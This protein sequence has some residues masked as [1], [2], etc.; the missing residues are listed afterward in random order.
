MS[1]PPT[2]TN[3]KAD[4]I[5]RQ[6]LMLIAP[7]LLLVAASIL[8][9]L[10]LLRPRFRYG[11]LGAVAFTLLAW[12]VIWLWQTQL[13]FAVSVRLGP[14]EFAA[15]ISVD[16]LSW[17]YGVSLVALALAT[18]LTAPGRPGF[19][20]SSSWAITI[21]LAGL[22]VLAAIAANPLTLVLVW[23]ALD[24]AEL[25]ATLRWGSGTASTSSTIAAFSIRSGGVFL[26]LLA[27]VLGSSPG[28]TVSFVSLPPGVGLLL[29]AAAALHIGLIPVPSPNSSEDSLG[30]GVGNMLRL[31]SAAAGLIVVSRANLSGLDSLTSTLF[32]ILCAA[33]GLYA[34][35]RWL[36]APDEIAGRHFWITGITFLAI[37]RALLGNPAG[38]AGWGIALV[39]AGGLLL[40]SS[41][42]DPW[43]NRL[44]LIGA[45]AASALPFSLTATA[46]T[47]NSATFDIALPAFLLAQSLLVAG[48]VRRATR[49]S[50]S[51]TLQ[52]QPAWVRSV[53][54]LGIG[55][56]IFMQVLLGVWGWQGAFQVGLWPASAA[57]AILTG[58]ILWAVPRIRAL[59]P[60]PVNRHEQ[61]AASSQ[62]SRYAIP[63]RLARG[64]Q[65]ATQ[66]I[67]RTLEGEAGIMWSLVFLVLFVSLIAGGSR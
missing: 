62:R 20:G 4:R 60:V 43:L 50:A 2:K 40:L 42:Q 51:V 28:K 31:T 66:T 44:A 18:L 37:G 61:A 53:Y 34:G 41:V 17:L 25:V 33:G 8:L 54:P 30:R 67:S 48:W 46:W 6:M 10:R 59:N 32:L 7:L 56:L 27:Q 15:S 26:L 39:L 14:A 55:L 12:F 13:P 16:D 38:A 64:I 24:L 49:L 9:S 11:W 35:W 52:S 65:V 23:A 58:V 3:F 1:A 22:G 36:R 29:L 5:E 45:W 19:P 21:G 63:W 57:A 47:N